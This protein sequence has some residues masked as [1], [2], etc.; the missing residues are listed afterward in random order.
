MCVTACNLTILTLQ[1]Y[2]QSSLMSTMRM[3]MATS[4]RMRCF[5]G[6]SLRPSTN[7]GL[8]ETGGRLNGLVFSLTLRK[9]SDIPDG[10][11]LS[12]FLRDTGIRRGTTKN[13]E[14]RTTVFPVQV[15]A[16]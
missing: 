1:S 6:R 16:S 2:F 5:T 7:Y 14:M 4:P 8:A 11:A 10:S 3:E 15:P 12:V 13:S 9:A